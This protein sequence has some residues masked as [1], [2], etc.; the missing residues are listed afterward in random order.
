MTQRV[1]ANMNKTLAGIY[2]E[3]LKAYKNHT[4]LIMES[5]KQLS[6]IKI[7]IC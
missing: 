3:L 2:T 5:Q 7:V 1:Y 4:A 6:L